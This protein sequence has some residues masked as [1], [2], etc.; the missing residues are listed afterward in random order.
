MGSVIIHPQKLKKGDL[1]RVVAPSYSMQ[2]VP[3][4]ILEMAA[5]RFDDMGLIVSF[6]K[7]TGKKDILESTSI[8]DRLEDLNEAF[9][10]KKVRGIICAIGGYNSNFLLDRIDWDILKSNPKFF[11][12]FS[13]ITVL[14]N[15][16]YKMT[17]MV[18]YQM[19]NFRN[20]GQKLGFEYSL[21]YFKKI[22]MSSEPV[23]VSQSEKWSDDKWTKD[24]AKRKFIENNGWWL[25]GEGVAKGITLGGNLCSLNLLQG[26]KYMPEIEDK[27]LFI[28]DDAMST[29][30]EFSRNLRSLFHV[31]GAGEIKALIL[32]RFQKKT[33]MNRTKL[34]MIIDD[35]PELRNKPVLANVDFGHTDPKITWMVGGTTE[36]EVGQGKSRLILT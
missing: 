17:G 30:G 19:P 4:K 6:G 28:E 8:D 27:I 24:Q 25:L 14:N 10:D 13:D 32:G 11:G 18:T 3:K 22:A 1:I 34:E 16:I 15:A 36:I 20:F 5:K 12:G 7:N 26:T 9:I 33:K 29:V 31:S 2:L 21:D 35:I 23:E